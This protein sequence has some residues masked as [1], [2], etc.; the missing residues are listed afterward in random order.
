M[1]RLLYLQARAKPLSFPEWGLRTWRE[2]D[3]GKSHGGGDNPTFIS[4]MNAIITD[5]A[6]NVAYHA[7]WEDPGFGLSDPDDH[8]KR[9]HG[10]TEARSRYLSLNWR[11]GPPATSVRPVADAASGVDT[12]AVPRRP[13]RVVGPPVPSTATAP[14]RAAKGVVAYA[15]G[16]TPGVVGGVAWSDLRSPHLVSNGYLVCDHAAPLRPSPPASIAPLLGCGV[17]QRPLDIRI[18]AVQNGTYDAYLTVWENDFPESYS[19]TLQGA[20]VVANRNSV[21][22]GVWARLGP[23][24]VRVQ[25]HSV[26]LGSQGWLSNLSGLELRPVATTTTK[27]R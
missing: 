25:D 24:R 11:S 19:I 7:P 21:G 16:S 18:S 4:R 5:P 2:T 20:V 23:F 26:R 27:R 1:A 6:W 8:P 22:A 14:K 17:Y 10:V 9:Q 15:F 3:D 12:D 13:V